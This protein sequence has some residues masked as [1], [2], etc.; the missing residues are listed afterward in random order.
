MSIVELILV[1]LSVTPTQTEPAWLTLELRRA[2]WP[3]VTCS[4]SFNRWPSTAKMLADTL[5]ALGFVSGP[6]GCGGARVEGR[7]SAPSG[8]KEPDYRAL[9]RYLRSL[10]GIESATINLP[11]EGPSPW[12]FECPGTHPAWVIHAKWP[13]DSTSCSHDLHVSV[14]VDSTGRIETYSVSPDASGRCKEALAGLLKE[15]RV[16]P[17]R[18]GGHLVR[19][20]VSVCM[21]SR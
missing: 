12:D 2:A 18:E 7:F 5:S 20:T 14:T 13:A 1:L 10:P 8:W 15:W 16:H 21:E 17:A 6:L 3:E 11:E 19:S 9:A 4:G